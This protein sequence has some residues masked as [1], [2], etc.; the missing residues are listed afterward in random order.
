MSTEQSKPDPKYKRTAD[1]ARR[2]GKNAKCVHCGEDRPEAL[3]RRS[4][5][6]ICAE[7]DREQK[8]KNTNDQHHLAGKNNHCV[9]VPIPVNDHRAHLSLAQYEWPTKTLQN[10]D[11]SPL[12]AIAACIQGF[13]DF[14][15]FCIDELLARAPE[16]LERLDAIL[17]EKLGANWWLGMNQIDL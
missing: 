15:R 9:T 7:C 11:R 16:F 8:G 10:P 17:I 13:V 3:I 4:K 5:P 14:V 6:R 1:G 12:I 2:L